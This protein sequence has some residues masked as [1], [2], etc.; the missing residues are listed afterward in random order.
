MNSTRIVVTG[1][2]IIGSLGNSREEFWKNYLEGRSGIKKIGEFPPL[3]TAVDFGGE[4]RGFKPKDFLS[5]LVYRKMGR[6]SR[7]SVVASLEALKDSNLLVDDANRDRIGVVVGTGYGNS[8]LTDEY[9]VSFMEG[10]PTGANPLL[11]ADTVPNTAGS[12]ISLHHRLRGPITTFCQNLISAELAVDYACGL[13]RSAQA[14]AMLVGGVDELSP[15]V[16]HAFSAVKALNPSSEPIIGK[17]MIMGEGACVLVLERL[18]DALA[19]KATIYGEIVGAA[20]NS[21]VTRPGHFEAEAQSM[22]RAVRDCLALLNGESRPPDLISL[23]AN[24]SRELDPVEFQVLQ[25]LLGDALPQIP[26]TPLKY[27]A[28]EYAGSGALRLALLLL[29]IRDQVI[30]PTI[31]PAELIPGSRWD[32]RFIPSRPGKVE[33]GLMTGFTFGGGN[34]C[35]AVHRA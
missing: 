27:F 9:F 24:F 6:S 3:E 11:F 2:G 17:G 23:S 19:R 35:L 26:F 18:E 1:I 31:N 10:G 15:I 12:H 28:G 20:L 30:P 21:G 8:G 7:L 29:S 4:V 33:R 13:L 14:E 5:P 34:A 22:G 25:D 32:R 16:M